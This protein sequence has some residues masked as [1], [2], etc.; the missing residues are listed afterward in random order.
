MAV[1]YTTVLIYS[2]YTRSVLSVSM[3]LWTCSLGTTSDMLELFFFYRIFLVNFHELSLY[4]I[5]HTQFVQGAVND[6][7]DGTPLQS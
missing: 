5:N 2:I 1:H 6:L 4:C 3:I 7:V